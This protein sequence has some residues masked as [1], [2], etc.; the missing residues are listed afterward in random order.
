MPRLRLT[1]KRTVKLDMISLVTSTLGFGFLLF[2]CTI[3]GSFG[4]D[5]FGVS[6]LII[7][8][9]IVAYFF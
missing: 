5:S 9:L 6:S 4:F 2:G 7:G 8:S 3:I 1:D